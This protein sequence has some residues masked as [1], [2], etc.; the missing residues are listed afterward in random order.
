MSTKIYKYNGKDYEV[1]STLSDQEIE[2][3]IK[4]YLKSTGQTESTEEVENRG[5]YENPEYEGFLTEMGEGV[6]SG[7][8][9]IGQG[10]GELGELITDAVG[11]TDI[12]TEF[13]KD[14]AN[15]IRN[16]LGIDPAKE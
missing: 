8:I 10:I 3:K 1:D 12:E 2:E 14:T 4:N 9:G 7:L 15:N 6:I 11:I 13:V 5:T 16:K